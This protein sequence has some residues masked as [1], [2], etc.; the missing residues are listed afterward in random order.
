[1][2]RV[3]HVVHWPGVTGINVLL[4]GLIER[5]SPAG[6][7]SHVAWLR[8]DV[9]EEASAVVDLAPVA[10]SLRYLHAE[11]YGSAAAPWRMRRVL[12]EVAPDI[13]HTH[14]FQPLLL[15][16]LCNFPQQRHVATIHTDYPYFTGD[17]FRSRFKRALQIGALRRHPIQSVAVGH[18]V[19]RLLVRLGVP[20]QRLTLIENGI[21]VDRWSARSGPD[22]Q[23][24]PT[25][26]FAPA[27]FVLATV[28]RLDNATKAFDL[29]LQA[30]SR[31]RQT[32]PHVKLLI[33]GE[34]PDRN[35]L[36]TLAATPGLEGAV[37]F[38]GHVPDSR[39]FLD[40]A[41]VYVSSSV[42]EG[43]GLAV[44]E[45]MLR[46][47]PAIATAVGVAPEVIE[48]GRSGIVVPAGDVAAL[49]S[50]IGDAADGRFPL[51]DIGRLGRLRV[52][53]K[54]DLNTTA[55]GYIDLYRS[56]LAPGASG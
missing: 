27:D 53:A 16:S 11:G 35:M 31:A 29:L 36:R 50:A 55:K 41:D 21:D 34:G 2:M 18:K 42:V 52:Q 26:G 45:A 54:Y 25:V 14:S 8:G 30:L 17:D 47:L 20:R 33:I 15:G 51:D 9:T 7:E 28:G 37:Q 49:A 24:R 3:L 43:F 19:F 12:R 46:G 22:R 38:L 5:M 48:S 6:F 4:R 23:K 1:M 44:V 39:P 40:M 13:L 56:V 32:R 10:R